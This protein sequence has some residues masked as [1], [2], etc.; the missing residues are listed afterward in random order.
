MPR[1]GEK[2]FELHG[3][4]QQHSI[5]V[6][7]RDAMHGALSVGRSHPP[8]SRILGLYDSMS[9]L[10]TLNGQKGQHFRTIGQANANGDIKLLPEEA[11][12]LIERG[13]LELLW[14]YNDEEASCLLPMSLQS[15]YATL[16]GKRGLTL[17]RYTVYA[18]LKRSG[19]I[20]QRAPPQK[21]QPARTEARWE[22]Q[23][24]KPA[25]A[26]LNWLHGRI[27]F[28]KQSG[29]TMIEPGLYRDYGTSRP[30]AIL[31]D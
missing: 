30:R 17:E 26:V 10:T 23:N 3:T 27:P 8:K 22:S 16:L 11:L 15:A 7:S 1:R 4:N 19:Y 12:Y 25:S 5:L 21:T 6:A 20:V 14:P 24:L 18:G 9:G 2:D 31:F 28:S 13:S 29:S